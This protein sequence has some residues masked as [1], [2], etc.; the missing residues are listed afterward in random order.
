M[1]LKTLYDKSVVFAQ[2]Q[3]MKSSVNDVRLGKFYMGRIRN[4]CHQLNYP[5]LMLYMSEPSTCTSIG[6]DIENYWQ[7]HTYGVFSMPS[8]KLPSLDAVHVT[9]IYMYIPGAKSHLL[10]VFQVTKHATG[11][12]L[13]LR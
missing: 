8:T 7:I 13:F 5:S 6:F 1:T 9:A 12:L 4:Q 3:S 10:G 11:C 2:Y